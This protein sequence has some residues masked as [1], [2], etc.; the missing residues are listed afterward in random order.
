MLVMLRLVALQATLTAV[1]PASVAA[2]ETAYI[3]VELRTGI[4]CVQH[5]RESRSKNVRWKNVFSHVRL[6]RFVSSSSFLF[7]LPSPP[8]SESKGTVTL[9]VTLSRCVCVCRISLGG[10]GNARLPVSSAL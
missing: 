4:S 6:K 7:S 3:S 8:L 5:A 2:A 9:G 10:E 1:F